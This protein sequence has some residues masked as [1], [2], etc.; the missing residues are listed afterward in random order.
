ME[1][2]AKTLAEYLG[3]EVEGNPQVKVSSPSRIEKGTP[4]TICFF[5][6][7]KYERYVYTTKASI[8]LV[9]KDFVAK[10]PLSATLVKVDDAYAAVARLLPLFDSKRKRKGGY[11]RIMARL[12][13]SIHISPSARIGKGTRIYPGVYIGPGV[14]VGKDCILY[15]GVKIYYDCQVGDGT[16]IHANSVI[17]A[18]GFGFAPLPD[19]SWSKIEQLGNVLIGRNVEI[20]AC[21]TVDRATMNSTIIHDGVK[22]DNL[23]QVAHNVEIGENSVMAA[24]SGIAGSSKLGRDC[25]IGGHTAI[26]GHLTLADGTNVGGHSGLISDVRESGKNLLGFPAIDQRNFMRSY[27]I[28]KASGDSSKKNK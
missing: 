10:Q 14:I 5:A 27:A 13:P 26:S 24:M 3:G 12:M 28:F 8:L 9:N 22:I 1:Y 21:T 20:G 6:N 25:R 17:G 11:G 16:I 7:P 18:D 15:P 19:G 2:T 4:G 23:C